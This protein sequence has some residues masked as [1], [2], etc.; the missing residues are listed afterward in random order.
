LNGRS[1]G[2]IRMVGSRIEDDPIERLGPESLGRRPA[3]CDRSEKLLG[4]DLTVDMMADEA[5]PS[6][7]RPKTG[8]PVPRGQH[9]GGEAPAHYVSS[10]SHRGGRLEG[11]TL[12][13]L[14]D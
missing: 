7:E 12:I 8:E 2:G 13:I 3:R 14:V 10:R 5:L 1:V 6:L 4:D 9:W 11:K